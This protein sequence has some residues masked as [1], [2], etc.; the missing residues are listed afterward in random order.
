MER[1]TRQLRHWPLPSNLVLCC[2][3]GCSCGQHSSGSYRHRE[4]STHAPTGAVD[5]VPGHHLHGEH[6][7]RAGG[8]RQPD[9]TGAE[10]SACVAN[11]IWG[12]V[13]CRHHDGW[14]R[15]GS[16][17]CPSSRLACRAGSSGV[18]DPLL[19][20]SSA[21]SGAVH[22]VPRQADHAAHHSSVTITRLAQQQIQQQPLHIPTR[23]QTGGAAPLCL[24]QSIDLP[25]LRCAGTSQS[26]TEWNVC[27]Y[28]VPGS[29]TDNSPRVML[30]VR[31]PVEFA[32]R[33]CTR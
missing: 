21:R 13:G 32:T 8:Q 12:P 3:A 6:G 20:V 14:R 7:A 24:T 4:D 23:G 16:G 25:V 17:T 29:V 26:S 30:S 22:P 27:D 2:F 11:W 33:T 9:A 5:P 18:I 15:G 10:R 28:S 31:C 19:P 1:L